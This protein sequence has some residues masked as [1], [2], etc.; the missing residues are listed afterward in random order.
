M[1]VSRVH[2][3]LTIVAVSR[4]RRSRVLQCVKIFVLRL[5]YARNWSRGRHFFAQLWTP[6][7]SSVWNFPACNTDISLG[8][9]KSQPPNR[10]QLHPQATV[11]WYVIGTVK[12]IAWSVNCLPATY[13]VLTS[14]TFSWFLG[15]TSIPKFITCHQLAPGVDPQANQGDMWG[16]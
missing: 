4:C 13:T 5:D 16:N 14:S 6:F 12:S 3:R 2:Q 1:K 11:G 8:G 9:L 15:K 7:T 10:R